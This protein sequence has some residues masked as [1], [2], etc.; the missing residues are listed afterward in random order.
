MKNK[1]TE[2][3]LRNGNCFVTS[4]TL[5]PISSSTSSVTAAAASSVNAS[6]AM[7]ENLP[8]LT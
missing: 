4:S 2:A 1:L 3:Y 7:V 8:S 6:P 5:L